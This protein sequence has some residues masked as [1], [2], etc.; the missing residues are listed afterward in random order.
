MVPYPGRIGQLACEHHH[1]MPAQARQRRLRYQ[2]GRPAGTIRI[3][4]RLAALMARSRRGTRARAGQHLAR[5]H[6]L[7]EPA[8]R[9][10]IPG[11]RH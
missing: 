7:G 3:I 10:Q 9:T 4:R 6:P 2:H 5:P 11:R 1:Q 8:G